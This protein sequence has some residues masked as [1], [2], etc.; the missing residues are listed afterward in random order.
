MQK[1]SKRHSN[2]PQ[3]RFSICVTLRTS[4]WSSVCVNGFI[5]GS[6][7]VRVGRKM[8]IE[9][10]S[11]VSWK[12]ML[13]ADDIFPGKSTVALKPAT[14]WSVTRIPRR[15]RTVWQ[16]TEKKVSILD[17]WPLRDPLATFLNFSYSISVPTVEQNLV[18]TI[19]AANWLHT[20]QFDT[21]RVSS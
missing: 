12:K 4:E 13:I 20:S 1:P 15:K 21:V 5:Y 2:H 6:K 18:S 17:C 3:K 16:I 14:K 7:L 9:I 19:G 11:Q 10:R 8:K